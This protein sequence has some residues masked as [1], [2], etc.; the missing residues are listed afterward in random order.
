MVTSARLKSVVRNTISPVAAFESVWFLICL[1]VV[2]EAARSNLTVALRRCWAC[3]SRPGRYTHGRSALVSSRMNSLFSLV[4]YQ[5][6]K[7]KY[8]VTFINARIH[9]SSLGDGQKLVGGEM[10][11]TRSAAFRCSCGLSSLESIQ[12]D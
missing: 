10:F 12:A 7:T 2:Q 6:I 3:D 11:L 5:G 8:P 1:H 4:S 9:S